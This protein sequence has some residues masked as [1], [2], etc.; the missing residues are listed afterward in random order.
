LR[1]RK[2]AAEA[3]WAI[4]ERRRQEY[5]EWDRRV[6][7]IVEALKP[8]E[9]E[10]KRY[11][12][13]GIGSPFGFGQAILEPI[14][15]PLYDSV[16]LL[17]GG[18]AHPGYLYLFTDTAGKTEKDIHPAVVGG[19]MLGAPRMFVLHNVR[20]ELVPDVSHPGQG[21]TAEKLE[22]DRQAIVSAMSFRLNIGVKD[23]LV[24]PLAM[25]PT[26]VSKRRICIPPQQSFKV[27]LDLKER[28]HLH[29]GWRVYMFLDGE[30]GVEVS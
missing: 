24:G 3:E 5:E 23:Y 4:D 18:D 6:E 29:T 21:V 15:Q 1:Q 19:G 8:K 26:H 2:A 17:A 11:G 27:V 16:R 13:G 25:L 7:Q 10:R 22:H 30:L 9:P 12:V 28:L 20:Y 14:V